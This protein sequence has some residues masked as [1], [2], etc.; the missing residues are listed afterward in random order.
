[1][2]KIYVLHF[3]RVVLNR[4]GIYFLF[5]NDFGLVPIDKNEN[6]DIILI[7]FAYKVAKTNYNYNMHVSVHTVEE[8]R[9]KE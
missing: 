2:K 3:G 8:G 1:M 4:K 7:Q 9:K 6:R 5:L